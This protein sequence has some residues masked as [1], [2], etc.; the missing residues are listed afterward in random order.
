MYPLFSLCSKDTGVK[1][2]DDNVRVAVRCRPLSEKEKRSGNKSVVR[3]DRLSGQ[4]SV[5]TPKS[6]SG[7]KEKI[8]TFDTVF[9]GETSQVDV[10]NETARPIVEFVLEGY[11][12]VPV[13]FQSM[14]CNVVCT[15]EQVLYLLMG[16]LEQARL[17]QW[18]GKEVCRRN[19]ASSQ[20]R[21][22]IFLDT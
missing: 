15:H 10:Y 9:G 2:K 20:T 13:L 7:E 4:V 17:T 22:L 5:S 21:L 6:Q 3:V 11:N 14:R 8:F 12:G 18:K 1:G 19:E 16:R